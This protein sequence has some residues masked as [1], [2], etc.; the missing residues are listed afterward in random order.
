MKLKSRILLRLVELKKSLFRRLLGRGELLLQL[1][2]LVEMSR[3]D[4][5]SQV[6]DL[7]VLSVLFI[8]Q[9]LFVALKAS[10][11]LFR[12]SETVFEHALV[13]LVLLEHLRKSALSVF[14]TGK[15]FFLPDALDSQR[16][17]FVLELLVADANLASRVLRLVAFLFLRGQD[18]RRDRIQ[19]GVI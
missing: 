13:V 2:S 11:G 8:F 7:S 16:L 1:K 19:F 6:L 4:L 9:S 14:E 12:L 5:L 15:S 3:L 10:L 18:A 17:E